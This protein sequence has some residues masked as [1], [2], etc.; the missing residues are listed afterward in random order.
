MKK[1]HN[2]VAVNSPNTK[3]NAMKLL[4]LVIGLILGLSVAVSAAILYNAKDIEFNPSD[5][6]WNVNNMQDAVND[7]KDCSRGGTYHN[8]QFKKASEEHGFYYKEN[9]FDKKYGWSFSE[10][11]NESIEKI[12]AFGLNEELFSLKRY[13]FNAVQNKE[14]KKSNIIKWQCSCGQIV[15]SS[16]DGLNI[17]C[18][19][20]GS[21]FEKQ[22]D[23]NSDDE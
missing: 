15:R 3:T 8:S 6:S 14:K 10:L 19:D 13:D 18:G 17:I 7:I 22:E 12:K 9:A 23:T 2:F 4:F 21:K 5:E 16:K 20:C 1:L 11:T